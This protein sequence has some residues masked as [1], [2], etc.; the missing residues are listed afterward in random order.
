MYSIRRITD[1]IGIENRAECNHC[2]E[3]SSAF[4]T[5]LRINTTARRA[6]HTLIG[7]NEAFRTSTREFILKTKYNLAS[8]ILSKFAASGGL[9]YLDLFCGPPALRVCRSN[10]FGDVSRKAYEIPSHS[11][12][13]AFDFN[14]TNTLTTKTPSCFSRC[15]FEVVP[16][17]R[18]KLNTPSADAI[19]RSRC[20]ADLWRP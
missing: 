2:A 18:S 10:I 5:P 14:L 6:V 15:I 20:L 9:R 17:V 4:A 13:W 3:L 8:P 11:L 1:G 7:S 19:R 12:R 16:P